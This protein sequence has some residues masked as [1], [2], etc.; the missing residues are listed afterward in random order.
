MGVDI[1]MFDYFMVDEMKKVVEKVEGR[2]L[3]EVL[4]NINI[5]N[6]EEIVKIGVDII[7]VGS[8]IYLVKSFDISFDFVD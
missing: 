5:D 4:G 8:I 3:I 7:F 6:I 2:V 1:I